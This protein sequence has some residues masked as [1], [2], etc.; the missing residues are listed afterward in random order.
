MYGN[1]LVLPVSSKRRSN[2]I[3]KTLIFKA[4]WSDMYEKV[5]FYKY[6][7]KVGQSSSKHI[8]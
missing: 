2:F 1:V 8:G 5:W 6:P 3:D 7:V 4:I